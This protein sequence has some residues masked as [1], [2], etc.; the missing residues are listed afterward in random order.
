MSTLL[1]KFVL[2]FLCFLVIFLSVTP[3]LVPVQAQSESTWYNT[4]FGDWYKKVYDENTSPGNEI[5]GERYTAA[6]VQW[7]VYGLASFILNGVLGN[8]PESQNTIACLVGT[9]TDLT[10]CGQAIKGLLTTT[11]VVTPVATHEND[12]LVSMVFADRPISGVSYIKEKIQNF[13]LVPV[14]KAQTTPGFG[15][16]ALEPI[17]SMWKGARDIAFGLFVLAAIILSF[18]IMFRVKI[19]P[20]VVISVQSAIPKLIIALILVTF[21]Y[22]IAGLMID[23]MYVVIGLVS[24]F[25]TSLMVF[26]IQPQLLFNFLTGTS[27]FLILAVYMFALVISFI[28]SVAALLGAPM[29]ASLTASMLAFLWWI[30]LIL[31]L[32]LIITFIVI[33]VKIWWSLLKAFA[34]LLLTVIFGPLQ[35]VAGV[36][37][38]SLGFGSW[39]KS[40]V[41]NL[42]VF[43]VSGVLMLLS[44]VFLINGVMFG[45]QDFFGG[46]LGA[47]DFGATIA[48]F[49]FGVALSTAVVGTPSPNWPPLIGGG[50]TSAGI[51]LLYLGVSFVLLTMIPKA[52]EIVQGFMTGK[53]FAYGS[54]VG[55]AI[56]VASMTGKGALSIYTGKNEEMRRKIAEDQGQTYLPTKTTQFLRTVGILKS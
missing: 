27:F 41:S 54:A 51:G 33:I 46:P 18:M 40:L 38:P 5:F 14:A 13:D 2:S 11:S 3:G 1:K 25:G 22:A 55:E 36:V 8:T 7:V 37:V 50:D 43:V 30:V 26:E 15:F 16:S 49:I 24:L 48:H 31:L 12:S 4:N 39:I 28:G 21:S 29:F 19:S 56:G 44:V 9:N 47:A 53:P 6:Q 45:L 35:I 23:L 10:A 42:S 52:T 20:Q 34:G 17:Q 32:A